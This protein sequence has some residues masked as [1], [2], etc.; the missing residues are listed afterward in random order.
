MLSRHPSH[1]TSDSFQFLSQESP[2]DDSDDDEDEVESI[3]LDHNHEWWN[4]W[5]LFRRVFKSH[6]FKVMILTYL[7]GR[8]G[9]YFN[10]V[11]PIECS[12]GGSLSKIFSPDES[13]QHDFFTKSPHRYRD[14]DDRGQL[15]LIRGR[16]HHAG[17]H[18]GGVLHHVPHSRHLDDKKFPQ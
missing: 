6:R 9:H 18:P 5:A 3:L 10:C 12:R 4:I 16:L 11:F 1:F 13:E 8:E 14:H 2:D 7:W 15:L 17:R